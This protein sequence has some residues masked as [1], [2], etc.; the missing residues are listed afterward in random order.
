MF[1]VMHAPGDR[2]D[3]R[4][5]YASKN[6]W[7]YPEKDGAPAYV[8]IVDGIHILD[9]GLVIVMNDNGKTVAKYKLG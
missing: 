6:V 5:L 8:T 9:E 1:T 4:I 7:F 3:R 2:E